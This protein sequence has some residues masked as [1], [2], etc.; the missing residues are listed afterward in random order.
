VTL[1]PEIIVDIGC[2]LR[3]G[4]GA[5]RETITFS[6]DSALQA[7][8]TA[9]LDRPGVHKNIFAIPAADEPWLFGAVEPL[10]CSLLCHI[11]Y[12]SSFQLIYAGE[13]R[14]Y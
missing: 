11:E 7:L 4:E 2:E 9:R 8:E 6:H 13:I 14:K 5:I 1:G 12:W 3:N 10:Y